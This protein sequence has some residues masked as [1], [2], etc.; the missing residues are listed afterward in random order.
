MLTDVTVNVNADG[1]VGDDGGETVR[2][3]SPVPTEEEDNDDGGA[4][5]A[6]VMR[7][8]SW[9]AGFAPDLGGAAAGDG[10]DSGGRF[11]PAG[12]RADAE[13]DVPVKGGAAELTVRRG[14]LVCLLLFVAVLLLLY[15]SQWLRS[16]VCIWVAYIPPQECRV[17]VV[18]RSIDLTV[19][20]TKRARAANELG[21]VPNRGL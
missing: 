10:D 4:V 13:F 16:V 9:A 15:T 1:T 20:R 11:S 17:Y 21:W 18:H 12:F 2:T 6:E 14:V 19:R 8:G 3:D 5:D 7:D